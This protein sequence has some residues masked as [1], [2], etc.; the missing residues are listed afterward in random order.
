MLLQIASS[1]VL[2]EVLDLLPVRYNVLDILGSC[3]S[4][5]ENDL[6]DNIIAEV[7]SG[8]LRKSNMER[9]MK[10]VAHL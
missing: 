5:M 6:L 3:L 8:S 4:R 7:C 9:S 10:I 2:V 1:F